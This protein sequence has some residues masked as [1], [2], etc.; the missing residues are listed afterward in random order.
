[1]RRN[2]PVGHPTSLPKLLPRKYNPQSLNNKNVPHARNV[3]KRRH[4]LP[5]TALILDTE[6]TDAAGRVV[7]SSARK[8][9]SKGTSHHPSAQK[10]PTTMYK[11]PFLMARSRTPLSCA[12]ATAT[13]ESR[14]KTRSAS[15]RNCCRTAI[16]CALC[17]DMATVSRKLIANNKS[18]LPLGAHRRHWQWSMRCPYPCAK[19][20]EAAKS[21]KLWFL[22]ARWWAWKAGQ[23][24]SSH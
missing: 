21:A 24:S 11:L 18:L 13:G 19:A 23:T 9:L 16:P 6:K 7:V 17:S 10:K 14:S 1:M 2:P 15:Y 22:T 3:S 8:R 12:E 4:N 5:S 20:T